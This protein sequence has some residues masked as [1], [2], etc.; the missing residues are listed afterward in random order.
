MMV[1]VGGEFMHII[2][3]SCWLQAKTFFLLKKMNCLTIFS[4]I[5]QMTRNT[6]RKAYV[7]STKAI[8]SSLTECRSKITV[9]FPAMFSP[10][11]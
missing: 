3:V 11:E 1:D 4:F 7:Q 6:T 10:A 5:L 8:C 2:H 9:N